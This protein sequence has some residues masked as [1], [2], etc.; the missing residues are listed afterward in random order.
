MFN[1]RS[2]VMAGVALAAA[3]S[4]ASVAQAQAGKPMLVFLGNAEDGPHKRWRSQA[5]PAFQKSDAFR[6]LDYR[7][8]FPKSDELMLK[9]A[10][11]PAD[12]RWVLAEFLNT[13]E[14]KN[15]S[16]DQPH[17]IL[18]Q[19]KKIVLVAVGNGGWTDK[20]LPKIAEVTGAKAA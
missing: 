11:W 5:E 10:S 17:F 3:P 12:A 13:K 2:V 20:M 14:G 6:K 1:R 8:V 16:G 4:L 9:E 18:A 19:D 7:V 15:L